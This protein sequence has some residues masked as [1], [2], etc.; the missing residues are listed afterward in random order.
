MCGAVDLR[1]AEFTAGPVLAETL[2]WRRECCLIALEFKAIA[3]AFLSSELPLFT[4]L[5]PAKLGLIST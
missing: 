2:G 5:L 4:L 3:D 1:A